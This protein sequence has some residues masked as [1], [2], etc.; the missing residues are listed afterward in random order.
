MTRVLIVDDSTEVREIV[1]TFLSRVDSG[2]TVCGE[3][4]DGLQAIRQ[5]EVLKPDLILIDLRMP[6]MNGIEA[7]MVVK[8]VLPKTQVVLF[9][10]YVEDIGTAL[11]TKSGVDLIIAK[12]SLSDMALALKTLTK[13]DASNP[14]INN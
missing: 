13:R 11:A 7:A 5:A 9:T 6:V 14:Q 3:A 8:R 2:Y 12:G 10:N 1:R 4:A